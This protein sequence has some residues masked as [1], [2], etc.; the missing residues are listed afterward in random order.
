MKKKPGAK[1]SVFA[2]C[3]QENYQRFQGCANY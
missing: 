1:Y 3:V 2:D